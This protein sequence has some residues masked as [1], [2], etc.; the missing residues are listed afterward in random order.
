MSIATY[1][2]TEENK[3]N[4][5]SKKETN[6]S[7]F[8]KK[9]IQISLK[10]LYEKKSITKIDFEFLNK[11]VISPNIIGYNKFLDFIQKIN[12][13]KKNEIIKNSKM[14]FKDIFKLINATEK[15]IKN[16][17]KKANIVF[18]NDQKNGIIKIMEFLSDEKQ[19]TFGLY[20]YA[21]TGKTTTII[22]LLN[23]LLNNKHIRS[24]VF[25]APTNKAVNVLKTKF[26]EDID[27]YHSASKENAEKKN[28]M[29]L[30][31]KLDE[32]EKEDI[33]V[34]FLTIHKLLN[35]KND[36]NIDGERIFFKGSKA[37]INNFDLVIVDECSMIPF[38]IISDIFFEA[39]GNEN[40]NIL[41]NSLVSNTQEKKIPK[42][43]FLGDPA[44]LPPVDE[45]ISL[46]F[47][48]E[49][50]DFDI[51]LFKK[52][53][54]EQTKQGKKNNLKDLGISDDRLKIKFNKLQDSVLNMKFY[55]LT[56]VKR[57]NDNNVVGICN[58]VRSWVLNQIPVPILHKYKGNKVYIY[59]KI[60]NKYESQWFK[61]CIN[62]F[63]K[64]NDNTSNIILTWTNKQTDEY[65]DK[66][67]KIIYNKEKLNKYEIGDLLILKDYY[68]LK[69]ANAKDKNQNNWKTDQKKFYTSEQIKITD[70]EHNTKIIPDF[71]PRIPKK[72]NN[73]PNFNDVEEK[74]IQTIQLINKNTCRKYN[75]WNLFVQKMSD[76]GKN[77][78]PDVYN[79]FVIEDDSISILEKD[80]KYVSDK[81]KDLIKYYRIVHKD[82]FMTLDYGIIR[83]LWKE[84]SEKLFEPFA[85]VDFANSL[86]IHKSQASSFY[87]VFI[88]C[89]D[90]FKNN[91][92]D[93]TKRLI[94]TAMTRTSN[95]LHILF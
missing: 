41:P 86:S 30:S 22:K 50:K 74:Y 77:T 4:K 3:K 58:E 94:Y 92:I 17:E 37:A 34:N 57:S 73:I 28:D 62:Y 27:F 19:K 15:N 10:D 87:N 1:F 61:K 18:T 83:L 85:N 90:V 82:N 42:V 89:D 91:D 5:N 47:A 43:L 29:T 49:R 68:N 60:Q 67:R 80:K 72:F 36:F 21:G 84:T 40:P 70:I 25:T 44:Q 64:N 66:I 65:N 16:I 26:K 69:E 56:E 12:D 13:D 78:I 8:E 23:Y 39:N 51:N 7:A 55:T 48:K 38:Q 93:E 88:D 9:K 32:L 6:N 53:T 33:K 14:V 31:Q 20:G 54:E 45:K 81:I 71:I 76:V 11:F 59:K 52:I 63:K 46:I 95:E 35:Y 24:V 2:G 75:V 79:L